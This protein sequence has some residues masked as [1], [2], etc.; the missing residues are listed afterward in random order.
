MAEILVWLTSNVS[1]LCHYTIRGS[2]GGA[3]EDEDEA[4]EH[5][6]RARLPPTHRMD[7]SP[8][9]PGFEIF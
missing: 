6:F 1:L 3:G 7:T 4:G 9:L 5:S 8:A 2:C